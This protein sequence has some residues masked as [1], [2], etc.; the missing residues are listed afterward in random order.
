[1]NPMTSAPRILAFFLC[2]S[3]TLSSPAGAFLEDGTRYKLVPI[4]CTRY[5]LVPGPV[6]RPEPDRAGLEQELQSPTTG[7]EENPLKQACER[8]GLTQAEF[9]RI[10]GSLKKILKHLT[11]TNT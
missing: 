2:L 1:M 11:C 3:L 9:G 8:L 7:L 4:D 6:L 10:L 5:K